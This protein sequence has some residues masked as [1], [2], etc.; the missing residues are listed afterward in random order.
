VH[1]HPYFSWVEG[2][3]KAGGAV[4]RP[5]SGATGDATRRQRVEFIEASRLF[6]ARRRRAATSRLA[7]CAL[8][9]IAKILF[10]RFPKSVCLETQ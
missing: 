7:I 3:A 10:I 6:F 5:W 8:R 2:L 9:S 4:T 1:E